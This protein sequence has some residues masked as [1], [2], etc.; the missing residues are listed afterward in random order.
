MR[1]IYLIRYK[2]ICNSLEDGVKQWLTAVYQNASNKKLTVGGTV[3]VTVVNSYDYGE[4][5]DVLISQIQTELDPEE[6]AGEG[7]GIAP[8]G[9]VVRVKSATPVVINIK[10][11]LTYENGYSWSKLQTSVE[12]VIQEYLLEL[13]K[14]WADASVTVVRISQ[15]EAR[16]LSINGI[17]DAVGTTVNES[18]ENISLGTYEIPVFGGIIV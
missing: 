15:I 11:T 4:V 12:K 6:N 8:I 7:Y 14:E 2:T 5:S 3:L 16:I 18:T 17:I 10:T 1:V 13:R 9:H